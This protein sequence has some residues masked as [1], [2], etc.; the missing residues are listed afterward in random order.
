MGIQERKERERRELRELIMSTA[1]RLFRERGYDKTSI[2]AIAE[3]IEY[4]PG[5]IYNHFTDKDELLYE[6]SVR[7]FDMFF[8]YISRVRSVKDPLER[9][10]KLG[11]TYL[12][13]AIEQPA[14][15]ELMFIMSDPMRSINKASWKEGLK[16][17]KVLTDILRDCQKQGHFEGYDLDN[18]S[19]MIWSEVHGLSSL[20]VKERLHMYDDKDDKELIFDALQIFNQAL[21]KL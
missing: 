8:E 5:T 15:Y 16:N 14:Y 2:R 20:L 6:V 7:A 11:E 1:A 17:H 21:K 3:E 9:L 13:F 19:M 18:L 10:F 4:S 12:T